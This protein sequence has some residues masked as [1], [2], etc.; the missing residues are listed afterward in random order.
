MG[1]S[2]H[3]QYAALLPSYVA[4]K[5]DEQE[6]AEV[7][8]HLLH[9]ADCRADLNL[10][11][12][13]AAEIVDAD[14]VVAAPLGLAEAALRQVW[15]AHTLPGTLRRAW[16]L[17]R[18]QAFLVRR[19][20][21]PTSAA[22]M[23]LGVAMALFAQKEGVI[24]F[25]A[26]LVA[27]ASL[28]VLFGPEHD[29]AFELASAAPT[30]SWQILLA[31]MALV[32]GYNLLLTLAASLALLV[33]MPFELLGALI[34]AWLGPLT[35]LSVLAL[36]LS[37]WIGT[38]NAIAVTYGLWLIPYPPYQ[39]L[40]LWQLPPS[41]IAFLS[42][43]RDFWHRPDLLLLVAAILLG[44]ALLSANRPRRALIGYTA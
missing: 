3:E 28:A 43:Y 8:T 37:L 14:R 23:A 26:P 19:E 4:G 39:E 42:D 18:A 33:F 25:F 40:H 21:W 36:L 34:L 29:P 35:L 11:Q 24:Y 13:L 1:M 27:A 32:S 38:A 2:P 17:L 7:E 41:W 22:V 44:M 30:S 9:C 16:Q 15:R 5:L 20:L 12:A 6:C 31:R 10:W